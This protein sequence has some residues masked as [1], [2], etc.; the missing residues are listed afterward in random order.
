M[1]LEIVK[2]ATGGNGVPVFFINYSR[3]IECFYRQPIVAPMGFKDFA[4]AI[5]KIVKE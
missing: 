5:E 3:E 4:R 2:G 1:Y